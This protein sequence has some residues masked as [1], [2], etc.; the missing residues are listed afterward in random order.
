MNRTL[1]FDNETTG[2]I[3][4]SLIN[5]KHQP[6]VIEFFGHI[7]DENGDVVKELEFFCNPGHKL[8]PVITRI[9]G[10]KDEDLKGEKPFSDYVEQV[11]ALIEEADSVVAHNLSFDAAIIQAEMD[12]C[13]RKFQWPLIRICTVE[14]TEWYKGYRLNLAGLHEHLFGEPF[15]G[16]H[17]ARI[18]VNALTKCFLEM[19]ERGDL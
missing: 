5:E 13:G 3:A 4:N 12:R 9:T 11:A 2:L 15:E 16:A 17:R 19:R 7:V 10:I 14:E 18:D 8:D 1:I 6:K